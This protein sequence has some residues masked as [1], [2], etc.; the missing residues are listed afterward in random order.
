MYPCI[1]VAVPPYLV[2]KDE[3]LTGD[4]ENLPSKLSQQNFFVAEYGRGL[5]QEL[6]ARKKTPNFAS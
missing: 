1:V 5:F 2:R 4:F 3:E 6:A